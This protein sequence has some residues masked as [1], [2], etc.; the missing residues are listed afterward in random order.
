MMQK[1]KTKK[2]KI[3]KKPLTKQEWHDKLFGKL[4]YFGDGVKYQRKMRD[5]K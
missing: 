4:K 3:A 2:K 1:A 5:G